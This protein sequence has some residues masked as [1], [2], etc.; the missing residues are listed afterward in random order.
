MNSS[1]APFG[2]I[3]VVPPLLVTVAVALFAPAVVG[4]KV[5]LS[6]VDAPGVSVVGF[7]APAWNCDASAPVMA[8]GVFSTSGAVPV[9]V[10]VT[11]DAGDAVPTVT[12][13]N[14]T[15]AVDADNIGEVVMM[16]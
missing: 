1:F 5:R 13:P 6:V 4:R 9:L 12:D 2:V 14:A 10:S 15:A 8:T 11:N 7:G 16:V 3:V